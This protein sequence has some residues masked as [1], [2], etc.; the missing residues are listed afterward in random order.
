MKNWV[1]PLLLATVGAAARLNFA[2]F[3]YDI[4]PRG[5][6]PIEYMGVVSELRSVDSSIFPSEV[7]RAVAAYRGFLYP[8]FLRWTGDPASGD[9]RS[10]RFAVALL[11]SFSL[12]LV[13]WIGRRLHSVEAGLLACA[14]AAVDPSQIAAVGYLNIDGFFGFV[15]LCCAAGLVW[16]IHD[17]NPKASVFFGA[18]LGISLLCRS[19]LFA[20][21]LLAALGLL[22]ATRGR[23][24]K[25]ALLLPLASAFVLA[26]WIARNA[27]DY[28]EFVPFEDGAAA[29]NLFV[30]TLP[31]VRPGVLLGDR[32]AV[33]LAREFDPSIPG[34]E[35]GTRFVRARVERLAWERILE[36]PVEWSVMGL[37]RFV[38][39]LR[40]LA[41]HGLGAVGWSWP[42]LLLPLIWAFRAN[43]SAAAL[44]CLA[45]YFV[46]MHSP[47][48]ITARYLLPGAALVQLLMSAAAVAAA[49]RW[50]ELRK[51]AS[52]W[53]AAVTV[54]AAG[55][56][57]GAAYFGSAGIIEEDSWVSFGRVAAF[58]RLALFPLGAAALA[59]VFS[60]KPA[61]APAD[62]W[63]PAPAAALLSFLALWVYGA[64][65]VEVREMLSKRL[66]DRGVAEFKRGEAAA[67]A[68]S[69]TWAY[70][71]HGKRLDVALS[72]AT[73]LSSLGRG[74]EA[75]RAI[76]DAREWAV[77]CRDPEKRQAFEE[78]S[79]ACAALDGS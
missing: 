53:S 11:S 78:F 48:G 27:V 6:D 13:F 75:D 50:V 16:W 15:V 22:V 71:I 8:A 49:R 7:P 39:A 58:W 54:A 40:V 36:D 79:R 20:V 18:L 17:P 51:P 34:M 10:T 67:A 46:V 3:S 12:L 26:P 30:G 1:L 76:A 19:T 69:L 66:L 43:P 63:L 55:V 38:Y 77:D 14:A 73:V 47:M 42:L 68:S 35:E 25:S 31:D 65:G 5:G 57:A 64:L 37:K 62:R 60:E 33:A 24:W 29:V 56:F 41:G 74:E 9:Y 52:G 59:L 2:S 4:P 32:E 44:A 61:E 23:E 21:P 72:R 70:R 28:G 45:G